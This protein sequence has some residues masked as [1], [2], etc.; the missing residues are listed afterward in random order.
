MNRVI[1]HS[2]NLWIPSKVTEQPLSQNLLRAKKNWQ[3]GAVEIL[4]LAKAPQDREWIR[5]GS[6]IL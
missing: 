5:E 4:G 1:F 2:P 6:S 3:V